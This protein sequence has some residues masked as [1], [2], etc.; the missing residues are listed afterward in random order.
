MSCTILLDIETLTGCKFVVFV[1]SAKTN[2]DSTKAIFD[3]TVSHNHVFYLPGIWPFATEISIMKK[4][5]Y[6]VVLLIAVGNENFPNDVNKLA[7]CAD[8]TAL[9]LIIFILRSYFRG[10]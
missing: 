6:S 9:N 10:N 2:D 1:K 5:I 4:I 3:Q 8:V 7:I